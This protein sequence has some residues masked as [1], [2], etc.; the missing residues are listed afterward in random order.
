MTRQVGDLLVVR[1]DVL[2]A[3]GAHSAFRLAASVRLWEKLPT[4]ADL[5]RTLSKGGAAM[6]P[7][8][9]TLVQEALRKVQRGERRCETFLLDPTT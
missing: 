1:G 6:C 8:R 2:H 9:A 4:E 5:R 3:S 7:K